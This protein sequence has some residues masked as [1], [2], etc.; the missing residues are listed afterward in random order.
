[1]LQVP[2]D[3]VGNRVINGGMRV[4]QRNEGAAVNVSTAA[5]YSADRWAATGIAAN[6]GVFSV[7]RSLTGGPPQFPRFLRATV[8]TIDAA[9]AANAFYAFRYEIEANDITDFAAGSA[10][11]LPFAS[12]IWVRSSVAGVYYMSFRNLNDRTF[13]T[14][15]TLAANVW[16]PFVITVPGCVDGTWNT[17]VSAGLRFDVGL[18]F[19]S[20][21][22]TSTFNQWFNS[23]PSFCGADQTNLMATLN[24]TFDI[25]GSWLAPFPNTPQYAET[26]TYQ[27]ELAL[28]QRYYEKSFAQGTAPAQNV[29]VGTGE[30][31]GS[32]PLA[33]AVALRMTA[34]VFKVTKRATPTITFYNPSNTNA[35]MRDENAAADCSAS[36]AANITDRGFRPLCAGAAGTLVGNTIG[37][38]W[39]AASEF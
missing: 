29:G 31:Q 5:V 37:V 35:Q 26:R 23:N 30:F 24:A 9:P 19:G 39:D 17:G 33:G 22:F 27:Q 32:A 14:P 7:Q 16:T 25:T 13:I 21:R 18:S 15:I 36:S 1:M 34:D 6:V 3:R 2:Q 20:N 11:A 10:N 28:C 4:D 38:H 12:L 8:T